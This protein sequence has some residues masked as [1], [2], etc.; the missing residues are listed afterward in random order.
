MF[1]LFIAQQEEKTNNRR[2]Y[3]TRQKEVCMVEPRKCF[4]GTYQRFFFY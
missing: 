3:A 2:I 1:V 4:T